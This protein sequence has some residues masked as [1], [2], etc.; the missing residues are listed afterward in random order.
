MLPPSRQERGGGDVH[1]PEQAINY[2]S[3]TERK[4]ME[5]ITASDLR[6]P[7]GCLLQS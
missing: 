6:C 7:V 1:L 3:L 2:L 4:T 5:L